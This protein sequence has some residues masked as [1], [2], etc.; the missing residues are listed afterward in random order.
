MAMMLCISSCQKKIDN[1]A[2][3]FNLDI[4]LSNK[5]INLEKYSKFLDKDYLDECF[6]RLDKGKK[7]TIKEAHIYYNNKCPK[8]NLDHKIE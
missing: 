7:T 1:C 6:E 3:K 4:V 2:C 8:Y 5:N